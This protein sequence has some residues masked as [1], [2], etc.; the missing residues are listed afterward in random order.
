M[1]DCQRT[2]TAA[3]SSRK[4]RS[5]QDQGRFRGR[6]S[7]TEWAVAT[8]RSPGVDRAEA[9]V[10][11]WRKA[12]LQRGSFQTGHQRR[13]PVHVEEETRTSSGKLTLFMAGG[14]T[15]TQETH[16]GFP[17]RLTGILTVPLPR[18]RVPFPRGLGRAMVRLPPWT[19][20]E[21]HREV[22]FEF[23]TR[24][25]AFL[26]VRHA[27]AV[28]SGREALGLILGA[29][30]LA[31]GSTVAVPAFTYHAVPAAIRDLGMRPV[32]I[33]VDPGTF[34]VSPTTLE[35]CLRRH[36]ETRVVLAT[37]T[38]GVPAPVEELGRQCH[39][40]GIRL[41]EDRAHQFVRGGPGSLHGTAGFHSLETSKP[42]SAMG[43][44][45]AVTDEDALADRMRRSLVVSR[46]AIPSVGL[47]VMR[48]VT[49]S[50]VTWPPFFAAAVYPVARGLALMGRDLEDRRVDP[51]RR[52]LSA[53]PEALH[54][55]HAAVGQAGLGSLDRENARRVRL[56]ALLDEMLG[57]SVRRQVLPPGSPLWMFTIL[58]EERDRIARCLLRDRI[59]VK[60][61][62]LSDC[63][64]LF[65]S[66]VP[67]VQAAFV[68][69]RALHLPFH[70]WLQEGDI[71]RIAAAVTRCW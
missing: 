46:K 8:C 1:A 69:R 65:G 14:H 44:G 45:L 55:L 31:P 9:F 23:E 70:P 71:R 24:A 59:D 7:W 11:T 3:L 47:A 18:Q 37:H 48:Q 26:G 10:L 20:Q 40:R 50:L 62:V 6:P 28:V 5:C 33:D 4:A 12:W 49:Q 30:D 19:W 56:G 67:M 57:P 66:E 13:H 54:P 61:D 53:S 68:A 39:A 32:F 58:P 15:G 27:V 63:A 35:D 21:D 42:L 41:V 38:F 36:P 52:V 25:A 64:L 34:N 51:G 16:K 2:R 17:I 22:V 43:G 29:L 60:R